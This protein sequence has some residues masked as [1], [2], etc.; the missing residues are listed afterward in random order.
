MSITFTPKLSAYMAKKGYSHVVI[1]LVDSGTSTS[2]FADIVCRPVNQ[3]GADLLGNKVVKVL[4]AEGGEQVLVTQRA[5]E[6]D[7][8]IVFDLKSFFGIKDI[9]VTGVRA[10]SM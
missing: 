4:Q 1:E 5:L 10:W 8:D 7:E 6:Y 3:K 9:V 2:G